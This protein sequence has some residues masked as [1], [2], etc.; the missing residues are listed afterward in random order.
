V[1]YWYLGKFSI[2][3]Q[4]VTVPEGRETKVKGQGRRTYRGGV[5]KD[6]KETTKSGLFSL[7]KIRSPQAGNKHTGERNLRKGIHMTVTRDGLGI[8]E[9]RYSR[10]R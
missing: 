4:G 9:A 5:K 7:R 6:G 3:V 1:I 8:G 2:S 10:N